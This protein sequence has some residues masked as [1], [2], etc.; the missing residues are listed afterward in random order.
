MDG[1]YVARKVSD[2]GLRRLVMH[3]DAGW[4]NEL[5]VSNIERIVKHCKFELHTHVMDWEEI[6]D[7]QLAYL[8][9]GVAK[10][11]VPQDYLFASS[12]YHFAVRNKGGAERRQYRN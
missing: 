3:M 9:A 10:Q 1:S 12:L 5:A 6:R 2:L 11:D 4:N 7:L 8:R